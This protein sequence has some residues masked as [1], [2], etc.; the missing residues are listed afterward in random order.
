[1]HWLAYTALAIGMPWGWLTL[2]PP[3]L[4]AW[5][6]LKVSGLPLLEARL[7]QS[8]PGYREYMRTTSAIVPWPP[9]PAPGPSPLDPIT[10]KTGARDHD[11]YHLAT[12]AGLGGGTQ[13]HLADSLLRA[14]LAAGP[15][16]PGRHA[17]A[18]AATPARR[19]RV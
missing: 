14:R 9:R 4:M 17:L 18:H 11:R 15:A 1:M 8:R 2:F 16:D 10:L 6:L 12:V 13:R 19:T 7:V 3:V 5:L